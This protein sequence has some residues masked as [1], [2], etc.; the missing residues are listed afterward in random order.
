M[1]DRMKKSPFVSPGGFH[2]VRYGGERRAQILS[3]MD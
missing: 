1:K 2:L 3:I